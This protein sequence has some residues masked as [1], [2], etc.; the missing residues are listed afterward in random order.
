MNMISVVVDSEGVALVGIDVPGRSTNVLTS[1]LQDELAAVVE[2]ICAEASI[3]GAVLTSSKQTGFIVGADLE[4]YVTAYERGV[5]AVQ[6]RDL[7]SSFQRITR[8]IE[9]S[10]KPFAAAING[11]ALGG[12]LELA[13][14]CHYRVLSDELNSVV[15]LPE[16]S[17]GLL[18]G[19]GGTQRL[20]RLIG[21]AKAVPLVLDGTRVRPDPAVGRAGVF[22]TRRRRTAGALRNRDFYDRHCPN[23]RQ[24]AGK[25]SGTTR[26]PGGDVR[27]HHHRFRHGP[28]Y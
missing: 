1:E 10:G 4:D 18:P 2:N 15:G 20:P 21:L 24:D 5:T 8:R 9:T 3:R 27:G 19:G 23:I 6:A 22:H 14:A 11:T 26:N 17:V 13:L 7:S 28:A 12:G 16:V 25:L